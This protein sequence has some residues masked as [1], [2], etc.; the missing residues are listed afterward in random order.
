MKSDG[1]GDVQIPLIDAGY[2]SYVEPDVTSDG[3]LVASRVRLE[4]DIFRYPVD[5][6]PLENVVNAKRITQ[7][8][9]QVQTPSASPSGEEVVYLSDSGGHANV[10]VARVDGSQPPR[11]ITN[12]H[13]PSTAIGI[14]LW[15]PAGDRIVYIKHRDGVGTEE[16]LVNPD[17]TE[18]R[19]LAAGAGASWSDDGEWIYFISGATLSSSTECT[20]KIPVDGDQPVPVRCEASGLSVSSDGDTAYFSPNT[21]RQGEVWSAS[22]VDTGVPEPL[23][24]NLQSRVPL[25]PHQ[26]HLS[27]DDRWLA[28][29]LKDRGTT[30]LWIISTEDGSLRQI[31]DFEQRSTMIGRQVSWSRDNKYIFAALVETDADIVLLEGVL[32]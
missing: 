28:T 30:N 7:Q 29:P 24:T 9:G 32:P 14:P 27:S 8:T 2:A 31:T 25:W 3:Q 15:S 17:G 6:S 1:S 13:D 26:Y 10:W 19:R 16:W 21:R 11:Q 18:Q 12:E 5:G 22:P 23:V 20:V 4:S